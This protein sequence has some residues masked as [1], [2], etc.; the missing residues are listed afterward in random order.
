MDGNTCGQWLTPRPRP[1]RVERRISVKHRSRARL[2]ANVRT[3]AVTTLKYLML[4]LAVA[5]LFSG[6]G[7]AIDPRFTLYAILLGSA[8]LL[9]AFYYQWR[10]AWRE[11]VPIPLEETEI[12]VRRTAFRKQRRQRLVQGVV[13]IVCGMGL[14]FLEAFRGVELIP[15]IPG[16][17][18]GFVALVGV[19]WI[20]VARCPFCSRWI[21]VQVRCSACGL[22]I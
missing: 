4:A 11:L 19:I 17:M 21:L 8:L 18:G 6:I 12:A 3:P 9:A 5:T 10:W 14:W 2:G 7:A 1:T 13:P 22:S 15:F 20:R 16:Y